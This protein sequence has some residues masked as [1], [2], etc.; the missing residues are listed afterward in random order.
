MSPLLKKTFKIERWE[1][2]QRLELPLKT[3]I[4]LSLQKIEGWHFLNKGQVYVS[5]SGG[6]DSTVLL[7]LV[8]SIFPDVPAVFVDT[9]LEYPEVKEFVKTISNVKIVRPKL[10]FHK[11]IKKHGFP[12]VS[13]KV[14]RFISDLQNP[15]PNNEVTRN[16]RLT[17][18]S[19]RGTFCP[20]MKLS[21]KWRYLVSSDIKFS[22]KCCTYMKKEPLDRY[23][24]ETKRNPITGVMAS[25]SNRRELE[26]LQYG[27]NSFDN[28]TCPRS[29]PIAF[30]KDT[31]I[32]QY[33]KGNEISYSKIY[34][35]GERRT[36]CMFC[37]F[38][39]H[40]EKEPNRFQRMRI[41]HPKQYDYCINKLGCGEVLDIIDVSY[42]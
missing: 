35:M 12:A 14:A 29:T 19:G 33:L 9:G 3:K 6:K 11:I 2:E 31:D 16:L 8:R 39:V 22:D 18:Y 30:W 25:E 41:S 42:K 4:Q 37:M 20:S 15:T 17:G 27:C 26:Y 1:L 32:W 28:K 24:K 7:H 36:G 40:M 5:F 21:K 34:D 23:R 13:K 10:P 38:G